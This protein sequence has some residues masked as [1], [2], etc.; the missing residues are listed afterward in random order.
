MKIATWNVNSINVRLPH[1]LDWL[2]ENSVDVL[3]LQETKMVD[4][5]FPKE[6]INKAGYQV[7]FAGQKTY[8]GVAVLTKNPVQSVVKQLPGMEEDPQ[9]RFLALTVNDVRVVN[10]YVPNGA[11]LDSDKYPYKLNWLSA[12]YAFLDQTVQS[13]Q[14]TVV[15]GDFNIAPDDRDV[16]D[17]QIWQ[18]DRILVSPPERKAFTDFIA[19]PMVDCF[20]K[21]EPEGGHFSWWDY[22]AAAFRRKRGLRIDHILASVPLS[23]R[24]K[25]CRIDPEPRSWERP[26]DHTPVV[27]TFGMTD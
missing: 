7:E 23:D 17:P 4:E 10:V 16:Y 18:G 1:V 6:E 8:N 13:H 22:R 11:A 14:Y 3:C 15:V 12:L 20:R 2:S 9:K 27:A 26:S 5:R 21:V 24:L 19:L 25:D